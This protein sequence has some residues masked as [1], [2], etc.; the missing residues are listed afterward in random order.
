MKVCDVARA[1]G[2]EWYRFN[3]ADAG[4]AVIRVVLGVP[5]RCPFL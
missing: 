3:F 4:K 5:T 2:S 1:C